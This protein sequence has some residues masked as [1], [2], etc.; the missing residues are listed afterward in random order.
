LAE[1][2]LA[3]FEVLGVQHDLTAE[4]V[5][6]FLHWQLP[7]LPQLP[8]QPAL[9]VL[10]AKQP[11]AAHN[12]VQSNGCPSTVLNILS[13]SKTAIELRYTGR[14]VVSGRTR[15]V[16]LLNFREHLHLKQEKMGGFSKKIPRQ[17][18]YSTQDRRSSFDGIA[19]YSR[20]L[21]RFVRDPML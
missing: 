21:R 16:H 11:F 5:L 20:N 4:G 6:L 7:P 17:L 8:Q 15:T 2:Q 14:M 10:S 1:Q 19:I 13:T 12:A 3:S 18:Y 9:L